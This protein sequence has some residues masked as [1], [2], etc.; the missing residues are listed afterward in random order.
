MSNFITPCPR[1]EESSL[2]NLKPCLHTIIWAH[3]DALDFLMSTLLWSKLQGAL[4]NNLAKSCRDSFSLPC[5][6]KK[7]LFWE[8]WL[9]NSSRKNVG[10]KKRAQ[11]CICMHG[12]RFRIGSKKEKVIHVKWQWNKFGLNMA[13]LISPCPRSGTRPLQILRPNLNWWAPS[14]YP[15]FHD[16][17]SSETWP[18][19]T[20]LS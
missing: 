2:P 12:G 20:L 13:N 16:V 5:F 18:Q 9:S 15:W 6:N 17:Q 11:G 14:K 4:W 7:L 19:G 8:H 10:W 3:S 1:N